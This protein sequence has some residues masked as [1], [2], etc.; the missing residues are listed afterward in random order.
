MSTDLPILGDGVVVV[1]ALG[2]EDLDVPPS[3]VLPTVPMRNIEERESRPKL[4]KFMCGRANFSPFL[5]RAAALP[6]PAQCELH[7]HD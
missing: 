5:C 4:T 2:D 1:E 3:H 7:V 6:V